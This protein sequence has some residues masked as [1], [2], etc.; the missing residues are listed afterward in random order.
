MPST[1]ARTMARPSSWSFAGDSRNGNDRAPHRY[2]QLR[3]QGKRHPHA[4]GSSP[5][6]G[7]RSSGAAGKTTRPMT[8][9]ATA[10]YSNSKRPRV[11]IRTTPNSCRTSTWSSSSHPHAYRSAGGTCRT[12]RTRTRSSAGQRGLA[13]VSRGTTTWRF[14][15]CTRAASSY[16]STRYETTGTIVRRSV[17]RHPVGSPE[18]RSASAMPCTRS[19]STTSSQAVFRWPSLARVRSRFTFACRISRAGS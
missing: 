16:I 13:A 2:K 12:S 8:P 15:G 10:P 6:P 3:A 19:A 5:A 11:D 14:G 9:P 4:D 1:T 7:H 18:Q 17:P